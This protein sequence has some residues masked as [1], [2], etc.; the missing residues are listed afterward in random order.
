MADIGNVIYLHTRCQPVLHLFSPTEGAWRIRR[1]HLHGD[2]DGAHSTCERPQRREMLWWL[3]PVRSSCSHGTNQ[4][5][6][7][8]C[9]PLQAIL[10]QPFS[11]GW[12]TVSVLP[13]RRSGSIKQSTG[14]FAAHGAIKGS[15]DGT[16]LRILHFLG[17]LFQVMTSMATVQVA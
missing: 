15:A 17:L 5:G 8:C 11:A 4:C 7:S 2:F 9:S 13:R 1:S 3:E 16:P 12:K 14:P 6:L 10:P